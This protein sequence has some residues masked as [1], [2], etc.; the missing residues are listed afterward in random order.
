[1]NLDILCACYKQISEAFSKNEKINSKRTFK[2]DD[3][4]FQMKYKIKGSINH[5]YPSM[6][7][8]QQISEICVTSAIGFI[9]IYALFLQNSRVIP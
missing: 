8:H 9:P 1:M 3:N 2:N 7:V 6:I 4:V 5:N